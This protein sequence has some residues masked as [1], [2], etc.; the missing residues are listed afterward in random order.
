MTQKRLER[1]LLRR[2][3]VAQKSELSHLH[4]FVDHWGVAW[5]YFSARMVL[6]YLKPHGQMKSC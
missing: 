4:G 2:G 5:R 6:F 3:Q 1:M